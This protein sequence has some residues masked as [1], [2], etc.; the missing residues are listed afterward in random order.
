MCIL[1]ETLCCP[2]WIL[3]PP[4]FRIILLKLILSMNMYISQKSFI[5]AGFH[6]AL[7]NNFSVLFLSHTPP[8]PLLPQ[9]SPIQPCY[10]PFILYTDLS[11]FSSKSKPSM[12]GGGTHKVSPLGEKLLII[13]THWE[14]ENKISCRDEASKKLPM[15]QEI[16]LHICTQMQYELIQQV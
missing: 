13:Y 14:K 7:S 8:P 9:P 4:H 15:L 1:F 11:L 2:E 12:A 16:F 3:P 6:V 5:V 10:F